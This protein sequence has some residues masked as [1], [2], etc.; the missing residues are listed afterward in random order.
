MG[1]LQVIDDGNNKALTSEYRT[2]SWMG[3]AQF[4]DTRCMVLG[5]TYS[6]TADVKLIHRDTGAPISCDPSA[7]SNTCPKL[8][9]KGESGAWED[10]NEFWHH[11]GTVSTWDQGGGWNQ[12]THSLTVS[13][14]MVD[15]GSILIYSE[16]SDMDALIV[17]DNVS[18]SL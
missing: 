16:S 12:I 2:A 6:I 18:F 15:A 3:P 17:L 8:T 14:A 11:M 4:I 10:T 5:A 1:G 9:M 13:Q 7:S